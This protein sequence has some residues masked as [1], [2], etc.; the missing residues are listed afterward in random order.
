MQGTFAG[1]ALSLAAAGIYGVFSYLVNRRDERTIGVRVAL[2]ASK[3]QILSLVPG[4]SLKLAVMGIAIAT[5]A[6]LLAGRLMS[7][8]L[9]GVQTN[10]ALTFASVA[11]LLLLN[12]PLC[13]RSSAHTRDIEQPSGV[14]NGFHSC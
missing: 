7:S 4:S 9:Y 11:I 3:A 2:G 12:R 8:W 5:A 10:D 13:Y 1:L 14:E 6:A